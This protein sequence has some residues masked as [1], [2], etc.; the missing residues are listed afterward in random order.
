MEKALFLFRSLLRFNSSATASKLGAIYKIEPRSVP[1]RGCP[2]G[3][4]G[5]ARFVAIGLSSRVR[6]ISS[7]GISLAMISTL[8]PRVLCVVEHH[9]TPSQDPKAFQQQAGPTA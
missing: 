7:S 1:K 2:R 4:A 3:V 5:A 8:G 9:G 6:T